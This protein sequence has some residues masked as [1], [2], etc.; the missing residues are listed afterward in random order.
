MIFAIDDGM[1]DI[2]DDVSLRDTERY[3]MV[4]TKQVTE[5]ECFRVFRKNKNIFESKYRIEN[6]Q[7]IGEVEFDIDDFNNMMQAVMPH[8]TTKNGNSYQQMVATKPLKKKPRKS[9]ISARS[10]YAHKNLF[11]FSG[12]YIVPKMFGYFPF[13]DCDDLNSYTEAK[14]QLSADGIPYT[15]YRSSKYDE[16]H[17]IFCDRQCGINEAIDFIETYPCDHRYPW[18]ARYKQELCIRAIPKKGYAPHHEENHLEDE[19]SDDFAYWNSQFVKYWDSG[20]IP[21]YIDMLSAVENI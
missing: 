12:A 8:V 5:A 4:K 14:F 20:L 21:S 3:Q 15:A 11:P 16:H 1:L 13:L 17:W 6:A 2:A 19:F 18:I 7:E 10:N 9:N